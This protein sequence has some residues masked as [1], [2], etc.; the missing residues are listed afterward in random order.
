MAKELLHRAAGAQGEAEF[1][2]GAPGSS[3]RASGVRL[4]LGAPLA[5]AA[6]VAAGRARGFRG[7][8]VPRSAGEPV[9]TRPMANVRRPTPVKI[10][11]KKLTNPDWRD[12]LMATRA[13]QC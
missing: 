13:L 6:S 7:E 1:A 2:A 9:A 5:P 4:S 8:S 11:F 12:R 10:N 3:E